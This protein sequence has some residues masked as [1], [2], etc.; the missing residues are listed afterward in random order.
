[1]NFARSCKHDGVKLATAPERIN[2]RQPRA[3][4]NT[5]DALP[6]EPA[7]AVDR[8]LCLQLV[9]DRTHSRTEQSIVGLQ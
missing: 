2:T 6:R 1:M 3:F 9:E 5:R 8:G 7:L 4:S